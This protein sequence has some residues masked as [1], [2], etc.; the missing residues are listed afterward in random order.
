MRERLCELIPEFDLFADEELREKSLRTWEIALERG[1]WSPDELTELPFTLLINPC[2]A[3]Y[4]E[5]VRG[6]TLT[7]LR[8]AEVFSSIYGDRLP[9]NRE[10]LLAGALLHDIGKLVEYEREQDGTTVQTRMG[11]LIRHPFSG[12]SLAAEMG[13]PDDVI[14]II[15]VHAGEG[16]K[17][18]R[19]PEGTIVNK[20][21]L[22]NFESL[23]DLQTRK[24]LAA[25]LA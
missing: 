12:A 6:V 24:H 25:R 8:A 2:P 21:D 19:T 16:D 18:Q 15:A 11:K 13:L 17:V 1:G 5:H 23:R 10:M 22:M 9:I 20:S 4:I 3:S 7:A 14:H